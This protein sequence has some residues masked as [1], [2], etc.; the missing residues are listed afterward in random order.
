MFGWIIA[1]FIPPSL[2]TRTS[3]TDWSTRRMAL[4]SSP[5]PSET[6]PS[7]F[8]YPSR[9]ATLTLTSTYFHDHWKA[10][11]AGHSDSNGSEDKGKLH[12][13]YANNNWKNVNS[14]GPLL[15]FGTGHIY[16]SYFEK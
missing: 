7:S 13:T 2:T 11:L 1:S 3:M 12:L 15:R 9:T 16:N 14:R 5:F 8:P 4:T 6:G 10:S